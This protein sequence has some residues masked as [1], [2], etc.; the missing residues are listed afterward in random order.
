MRYPSW[1]QT[2][3]Q[4]ITQLADQGKTSVT[5]AVSRVKEAGWSKVMAKI[6]FYLFLSVIV[7]S[8]L[9]VV[10]LVIIA[11]DLPQPDQIV[12]R[13][14]FST[15]I[16]DRN[17]QLIYDIFQDQR[18]T[19]VMLYEI[20]LDLQN[21]TVAIEDKDF[22]VHSG[23]D[24]KGYLRIVYYLLFKHRL[25]GGSTLTQQLVKNVLLSPERTPIRKAKEL[26]LSLEIESRYSK[27]QILQMYLNEAPYGG[28]AWGV[29]EAAISYF[30]K[31]V[32]DLTLVESA[33]LAGLPQLPTAY[34]PTGDNP[35]AYIARTQA[36]LRR[37][38]EDG[39]I[40]GE[41]ETKAVEEL[42]KVEFNARG[43]LLKA[44]HFVMYVKKLLED[45]YGERVVEQGGLRVT[46]SLD[47]DLQE[48]AQSIVSEE[49]EK[50]E[51]LNITNGAAMVLD[52]KTGQILAMVGSKNYDD[53]DYDGKYNVATAL[54]QP[55]S[56]IKPVTYVTALKKGY[57]AST[58]L[59]DVTTTFPGGDKKE[60]TP[61][62][63][64]GKEHGPMQLRYALGNSI[65]IVAVKVLSLVGIEDMLTTAYDMGLSTL[66]PTRENLSRF[67]LSLTL[68]GGE[69][70]LIDMA[71]AYSAFANGGYKVEPIAILKVTDKDGNV[72]EEYKPV[73]G[74]QVLTS[75][76]AFLISNILSDNE[77]RKMTFGENSSLKITNR[78]VAVKTGT[79][80]D[81]RDNWTIGWTPSVVVGVWVGNNDN[82]AMKQ[83]VSGVS[84]AAP[85]WRRI[86][87]EYLKTRQ[88]EDFSV[89][90]DVVQLEVDTVS[91]YKAHN[92]FPQRSEYF[93]KGTE[94]T[95]EDPIH[96][97]LKLCQGQNKLASLV[98]I[99]R[100]NF[101]E[102]EYFIFKESD[103]FENENKANFW[104]KGID[105]WLS[106]QTDGRYHPPTEY[107]SD[108]NQ[109]Y[110]RFNE[111][112]DHATINNDFTL[113]L[114]TVSQN[115]VVK[116]DFYVDGNLKKTLSS[117]PYE[118]GIT[119][120]NGKHTLKAVATDSKGNQGDQEI[121]IGVNLAWDWEPSP[122]PAPTSTPSPTPSPSPS[123]TPTL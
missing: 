106:K 56:T 68:G 75:G 70:K 20:P 116:I 51:N 69:V 5:E 95:G 61:V 42:D 2:W 58:M 110:V 37:M 86:I 97:M 48:K 1:H 119:L 44:P 87:T 57:T 24:P 36:V 52:P 72:L 111:P 16:Y 34:S 45:K 117:Y 123:V 21:A 38:Q 67:G 112:S 120:D 73:T 30:N 11:K 46:T 33:I 82:S 90:D 4:K 13:E 84:G 54:R 50:V 64:D 92:S 122:T 81:K 26:I 63:Y 10:A 114:E 113:K 17:D 105:L 53:P 98:D 74:K 78:Q 88:V 14:G 79:T 32:K 76:E 66:E 3:K 18:R 29:Q 96:P 93:I 59:M 103:P 89:P 60:Y 100:N 121:K 115:E 40:T 31:D 99:A 94:P 101:E 19:P 12:R 108:S 22:F 104:Q 107:C 62:N 118:T 65:N 39:Y 7:G 41:Q 49:I 43:G 91:G 25:I 71:S 80:N 55:G 35:T 109:I 15:K 6:S 83:V 77:A 47:L 8:F 85:I 23:F 9:V 27:E 28:T 102:K